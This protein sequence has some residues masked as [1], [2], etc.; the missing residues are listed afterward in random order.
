V[1][2]RVVVVRLVVAAVVTAVAIAPAWADGV[3]DASLGAVKDRGVRLELDDHHTVE[4]RL[5]AFDA[6]TVTLDAAGTHEVLTLQRAHVVRLILVE[7]SPP[8]MQV[9]PAIE[10][11][12]LWGVHFGL[13]GALL[14]DVDYRYWHAFASTNVLLPILTASG[15][16]T[17]YAAAVGGGVSIHLSRRWKVDAFAEVMPL[18]YTSFY[19]YLS[20]GLG[21]GVHHTAASGVSVGIT[22]PVVGFAARLGSSP[23]GYDAPFRYNDSVGYF[24]LAGFSTMPLLTIGYRFPCPR[25]R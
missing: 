15:E 7:V 5:L 22:L 23:Y 17:W 25:R 6:A 12:R 14:V 18:R 10:P 2:G 3:P 20:A 13:P 19:T 21:V 16:H 4:G 11:H 1:Y 8:A 9:V 24:Y